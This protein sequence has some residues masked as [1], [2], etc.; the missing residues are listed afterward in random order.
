[1]MHEHKKYRF[2]DK[3]CLNASEKILVSAWVDKLLSVYFNEIDVLKM[4][5][6]Y[7][8]SHDLMSIQY[9]YS[10]IWI[11]FN[12][13]DFQPIFTGK[14]RS[15]VSMTAFQKEG[16]PVFFYLHV[17]NG[18]VKGIEVGNDD[19]SEFNMRVIN[20]DDTKHYVSS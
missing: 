7:A 14:F 6:Q 10:T 3:G 1:M 5:I 4:Q 15:P 12:I 19:L 2:V 20:L 17:E 8:F 11:A 16:A 13:R 18:I 9:Y